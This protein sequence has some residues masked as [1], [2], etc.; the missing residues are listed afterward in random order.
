MRKKKIIVGFLMLVLLN[1]VLLSPSTGL[2]EKSSRDIPSSFDLRDVNG[3]NFVTSVKSQTGGTCWCHGVMAAMEGNLMMTGNWEDAGE[4]GE[5]NLAEY[6]LDWW[7]GFNEHNNDD[8]DPPSGSGLEVHQGGDYRVASAYLTRCEGAVRDID[9]QSYDTPPPRSNPSFHYYFPRDIEWYVAESDLSNSD[10]IKQKIMDEGVMGTC[11][12][13]A[14]QFMSNY[15]HYQ[16]PSSDLDPNHAIGIIGWDD[17]KQTQAPEGDGAWLCKNSWGAG[18]GLNGFFWISYYDKHCCQHPEMG[19]VS[20][21]D[22]ELLE[23]ED[24]YYH[25]YHGWRDTLEDYSEAF[26]AFTVTEDELLEAVSFFTSVDDE[27]C[28]VKIYDRFEDGQLDDLLSSKSGIID[29]AGFHTMALGMPVGLTQG[30]DFYIYLKLT[31][32][33][34]SYDRT[35]DVPVLLGSSSRTIVESS[36]QSEQSY[37]RSGSSW[38][39]LYYYDF[40][41]E[42]WDHTANF[43]MKGYTNS[44]APTTPDLECTGSLGWSDA[45]PDKTVLGY[46][47]VENIGEP[48]SNLDWEIVEWPDW[49]IWDFDPSSGENLKPAG[50]TLTI[51]AAVVAPNEQDETFIG[52]I[53]VINSEDPS[54]Y[55]LIPVTLSTRPFTPDLECTGNLNWSDVNPGSTVTG[56]FNVENIGE[57]ESLLDWEIIEYP[58]WGDFSFIPNSGEDLTPEESSTTVQVSV[59]APDE[60]DQEFTGIIKIRNIDDYDD[61]SIIDVLLVT[62][63]PLADLK[64]EGD[65]HFGRV[66]TGETVTTSITIQNIGEQGSILDWEITE[67]PEWGIWTFE[68]GQGEGLEPEEDPVEVIVTITAPNN[69]ENYNGEIKI[70]NKNNPDDYEIIPVYLSTPK[71]KLHINLLL[72]QLLEK[73]LYHFPMLRIILQNI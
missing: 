29:Y 27:I 16:P 59:I 40:E 70:I 30:D 28:V 17:N 46:F 8:I 37:Y 72:V 15:V 49:G 65:L 4:S 51:R 54:D 13:Y 7:N 25:D 9:G 42:E 2:S 3:E 21:Q 5:P 35:S 1:A 53:K 41:D 22:V 12:C 58:E 71:N 20:F 6:H 47:Q 56:S 50:G 60:K 64:C 57:P 36:A 63:P 38:K 45:E 19:A 39:D 43:C 66:K 10:L 11:M 48:L 73:L 62:R 67:Y 33:G 24:V 52:E 61:F 32:G 14:S 68:P 34:H 55:G 18:W 69:K 26:N 44:W 23:Y 31:K